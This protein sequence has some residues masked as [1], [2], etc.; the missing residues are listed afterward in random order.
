VTEEQLQNL[1]DALEDEPISDEE[2]RETCEQLGIDIP[3][4][5]AR[6]RAMVAVHSD[7]ES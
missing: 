5:A 7:A 1:I 6:I 2:A 3:A 4:M